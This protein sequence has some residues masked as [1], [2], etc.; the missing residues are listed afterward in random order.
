HIAAK[1]LQGL[2]VHSWAAIIPSI[3]QRHCFSSYRPY[4]PLSYFSMVSSSCSR[5]TK[6]FS[7]EC[8]MR[9]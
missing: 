6:I 7:T 3:P 2:R 5:R 1:S 8:A 9:R 4:F